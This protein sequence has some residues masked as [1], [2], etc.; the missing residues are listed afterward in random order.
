MA[1]ISPFFHLR[2]RPASEGGG[3]LASK[4]TLQRK[5]TPGKAP[6]GVH[7]KAFMED[8]L[9]L[10]KKNKPQEE[11]EVP[12]VPAVDVSAEAVVAK[13]PEPPPLK[14]TQSMDEAQEM[15]V[16]FKNCRRKLKLP[17]DSVHTGTREAVHY[18]RKGMREGARL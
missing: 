16:T 17:L 6:P 18:V 15:P 7:I 12:A 9:S 5:E 4:R 2:S 14:V 3:S 8:N 13:V 1:Q 10:E 11:F